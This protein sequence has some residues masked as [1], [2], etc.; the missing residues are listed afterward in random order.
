[1]VWWVSRQVRV[2]REHCCDDVAVAVQGDALAYA[3][4]L[5]ELEL[6]R[7]RE[8]KLALAA[9][10]GSLLERIERVLGCSRSL[11]SQPASW[12]AGAMVVTSLVGL[13][14]VAQGDVFSGQARTLFED[15]QNLKAPART[16]YLSVE[17][18][19]LARSISHATGKEHRILRS[20]GASITSFAER[21]KVPYPEPD[22]MA[23]SYARLQNPEKRDDKQTKGVDSSSAQGKS[24]LA[25]EDYIGELRRLGYTNL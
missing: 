16:E 12:L 15:L 21:E 24:K 4:A 11:N 13:A 14:A 3:R 20:N 8:P 1:A 19:S 7:A 18:N 10:G 6:L 2:E 5:A 25:K 23:R 22:F 9:N 17:I